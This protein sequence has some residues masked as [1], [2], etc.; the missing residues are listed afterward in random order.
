MT[1]RERESESDGEGKAESFTDNGDRF[2]LRGPAGRAEVHGIQYAINI[3][4][5]DVFNSNVVV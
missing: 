4:G 1:R 5:F 3:R 2:G